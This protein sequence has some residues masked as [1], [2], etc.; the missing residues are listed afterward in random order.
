MIAVAL[1]PRHYSRKWKPAQRRKPKLLWLLPNS[2]RQRRRQDLKTR[3]T[4]PR[5]SSRTPEAPARD[6]VLTILRT[7]QPLET[8]AGPQPVRHLLTEQAVPREAVE[9]DSRP[10]VR[11]DLD[12]RDHIQVKKMRH[13]IQIAIYNATNDKLCH[14]ELEI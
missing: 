11:V 9:A 7:Q 1:T 8:A 13:L 6:P 4:P 12:P 2:R 5:S 3:E 10:A 14:T